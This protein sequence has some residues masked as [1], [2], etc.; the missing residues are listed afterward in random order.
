MVSYGTF[1][2]SY[3]AMFILTFFIGFLVQGGFNSFF[4]T[5]TRVY[6][7]EIRST[8]VGLAMG[9]GRFGAILGPAIFGILTDYGYSVASRFI[10]FSIP[11]LIAAFFAFNIPSKSLK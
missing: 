4:P 3:L 9:I 7:E 2:L 6:P 11:L 8:G 10:I 5:A 1:T